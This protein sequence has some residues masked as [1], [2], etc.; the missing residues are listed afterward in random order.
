MPA[1]SCPEQITD[2]NA[3]TLHAITDAPQT[4]ED[5]AAQHEISALLRA[6]LDALP[7]REA[8]TIRAHYGLDAGP[9]QMQREIAKM[10][11][12]SAACVSQLELQGLRRLRKR[13][14]KHR[15]E[16]LP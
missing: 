14:R 5:A 15:A 12:I 4:P 9:P 6:H 11:G 16:F 13:I 10:F 8:Y 7:W 1:E 3:A 2:A